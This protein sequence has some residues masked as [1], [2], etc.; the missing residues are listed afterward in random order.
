MAITTTV[1]KPDQITLKFEITFTLGEWKKICENLDKKYIYPMSELA[2]S[3]QDCTRQAEQTFYP[4]TPSTG[5]KER[6]V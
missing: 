3:I 5:K 4:I 1:L 2:E 6:K